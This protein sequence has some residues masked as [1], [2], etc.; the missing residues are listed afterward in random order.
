MI[1]DSWKSSH[2]WKFIGNTILASR[3]LKLMED[4]VSWCL[5]K[6]AVLLLCG[7]SWGEGELQG[8]SAAPCPVFSTQQALSKYLVLRCGNLVDF[9]DSQPPITIANA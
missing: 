2:R 3:A 8:K 4:V 9:C 1:A 5:T 7:R 6:Q